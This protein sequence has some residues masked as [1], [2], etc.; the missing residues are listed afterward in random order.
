MITRLVVIGAGGF[1]RETL[2]VVEAV[3]E[4][5][6]R[7]LFELVGVVDSAP[8][9]LN[10]RRLAERGIPLLGSVEQW[11]ASGDEAHVTVA[12]G[13][14]AVRERIVREVEAAGREFATLVHPAARLGS[15][16][17]VGRGAVICGGV[18]YSTNVAIGS[19]V[20][21]NPNATIGHDTVIGDFVSINPGA[22]VSGDV[23]IGRRTLVG[24]GAVVLQGLVLGDD[25]VVGAS[26]CVVRDVAASI[27]VKGVPAR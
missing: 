23:T 13:T 12:I 27:T 9:E 26:A 1:G 14:P 21:L 11:L 19:H 25:V 18:Q 5:A 4:A 15:R 10:L 17:Q 20:H 16:P 7:P 6:D 24:A 22:I 3:N 2:D 8:S